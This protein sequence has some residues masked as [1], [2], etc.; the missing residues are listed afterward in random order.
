[1]LSPMDVHSAHEIDWHNSS[2]AGEDG[3]ELKSG[4]RHVLKLSV[5]NTCQLP[6]FYHL[7]TFY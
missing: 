4:C 1:M 7:K 5:L 6:K 2:N 3:P